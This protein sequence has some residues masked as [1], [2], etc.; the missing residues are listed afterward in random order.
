MWIIY[1]SSVQ[2]TATLPGGSRNLLAVFLLFLMEV[3]LELVLV[4]GVV[5]LHILY[6]KT[7]HWLN[8]CYATVIGP[9]TIV[10]LRVYV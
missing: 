2:V 5:L 3:I 10:Y 4:T 9:R 1:W 6:R 8:G 7:W